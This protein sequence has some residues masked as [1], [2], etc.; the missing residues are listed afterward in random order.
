[1]T[2]SDLST[3]EKLPAGQPKEAGSVLRIAVIILVAA[4]MVEAFY[5]FLAL[6]MGVWQMYAL[7]GV[8]A[9]FCVLNLIAVGII[10][11]GKSAA[12]SW[13]IILGILFVF[14]AAGALISNTGLILGGTLIMLTV[15]VANQ[16][17][18]AKQ[19]RNV[20]IVSIALGILTALLDSSGLEYRLFVPAI[21]AFIPSI[22]GAIL[23][24]MIFFAVRQSWSIVATSLR[25]KITVWTGAIITIL[26]VILI[27]YST[28]TA[29]QSAIQTAQKE[30]LAFA[31]SQ[32]QLVRAD[33][34]VPL[35]TA[36]ALAHAL[37]AAKDPDNTYRNLSRSQV[38]AILRQV[39]IENPAFLGVYTL[40]EPDAFDGQDSYYRGKEGHDLTGRFIPYWVRSD[41]SSV[42]VIPLQDYETPGIGDWYIQPRQ[43]KK[44]IAIAPIFYPIQG[45]NTVMASF[46][47]PIIYNDKFYG[48]AGVDAPISFTQNIVD[49][50][51]LYN[52]KAQALLMDSDGTLIGVR[53]Q[54]ELVN[55]S[56]T[57]LLPDFSS[58]LQSRIQAGEAFSSISPDGNYLRV[59]APVNLG[60]T[61]AHWSF[62]LVIPISEITSPATIVAVR[63]GVIGI[64]L[65]LFALIFLWFL[66]NQLVRPVRD[67]TA[68]ATAISQGNLNI[69]AQVQAVDET[70]VLANAFN[71]MISQLREAF[72]T[73]ETRVA[74]RTQNLELAAEVGRTV[75]Q[76]RN[77]DVMLTEA[78]EL[79]RTQFD[80]YYVQVYLVNP[81]QTYLNLQA[82][83]G[84]VGVELLKRSHRLPLNTDSINGRAA[85]EKKS[86]VISDTTSS[87]TFKPNPLLPGTRSEI[88]VPLTI[89]SRVVGVLDIQ[90]EQ[91]GSL[92]D[93]LPAFEAMA[94]Q[95]AIAI[96]NATFLTETQQARA[97]ME[98]QAQRQSRT[99]WV[100]YLDAIHQPEE[101][102]FVFEQNKI[103]P[104]TKAEQS[105]INVNALT[106]PIS[107]TGESI[108][109]LIVEMDEQS[110]INRT[111]ELVN[112][113]A[114][115]VA[116]QIENLR[117]LDSA[118]RFRYEAEEASR[119]L[120]REGWKNYAEAGDSLSYI[121][122]LKEVRPLNQNENQEDDKS[123]LNLPIKV[124]D[125]I[126]GKLIIQGIAADDS[127]SLDLANTV[128][129]RLGAHI[130]GLRL[131]RQTE[132]ALTTTK[133]LAEREQAL[134]QITSAV[135]G[136][137]DP[138]TILR[139]AARELGNLLG[140]KTII[141]LA[142]AHEA[143]SSQPA[144]VANNDNE[145]ISPVESPK[146]D[147]GNE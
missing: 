59:F 30:A 27:A 36:R 104:M 110:P 49:K 102:G 109:N 115:Q 73:L 9:V 80:L 134:R 131:S 31:S 88:A 112:T 63:Q 42:G 11:N 61:G 116:Q 71:L 121:Y 94:G 95:L 29:R 120:T 41:D 92:Q 70:G 145:S 126:V 64:L 23:L 85:M 86:V 28:I 122:D 33:S 108:G 48:I 79:I 1:M 84:Q 55:Q 21:Q 113:V 101:T 25:L 50:V 128:A 34:E 39:L 3:P 17:L 142:T 135:R 20:M 74:E 93:V 146:T 35:D 98:A 69:T 22:T 144:T 127:E 96:Q 118:E 136:S 90:S 10:R 5:I 132:Q 125:E 129:E 99:N 78:A 24:V 76:V 26:S 141:R 97:E 140:R 106:A 65:I 37:T 105:Q 12:G 7:A 2:Q 119:R 147:G 15:L 143:Q 107:V 51:N 75:S 67:L 81:S 45:V 56:A 4:F 66:S 77:L 72:A 8:I 91:S 52:G 89:G 124:R 117:L 60:K 130:E 38:N 111:D 53:N 139:S 68:L 47:V 83:T 13:L 62:G 133:K 43:T 6:Q 123:A 114:R 87:P 58:D 137:T 103:A 57:E 19:A 32:A 100:D 46:V 40:W 138:A 16:T 44:E 14:P 82:G 18:P 54:P